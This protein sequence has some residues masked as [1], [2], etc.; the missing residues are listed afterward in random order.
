M[1]PFV[2]RIALGAF[3]DSPYGSIPFFSVHLGI[4]PYE[5]AAQIINLREWVSEITGP[6]PAFIG[7][8][9]NS[10]E[11]TPQ[12]RYAQGKWVDTFR[13]VH[14]ENDGT[15]HELYWPWGGLLRRSRLDYIFLKD[16][17]KNWQVLDAQHLDSPE[18][19]HSDH[20]AVITRVMPV[21]S[22]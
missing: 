11:T 7:G 6:R 19:S 8:D 20:K 5:N 10:H 9:F 12:I 14:P 13:H 1:N 16:S 21:H 3:I 22:A 15:T 4:T 2:R 18:G 17:L